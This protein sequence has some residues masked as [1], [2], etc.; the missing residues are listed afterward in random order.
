[1]A[2]VNLD[3][4]DAIVLTESVTTEVFLVLEI[5]TND[6]ITVSES[7]TLFNELLEINI[8]DSII[9]IESISGVASIPGISVNDSTSLTEYINADTVD[10]RIF[11]IT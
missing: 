1:M 6:S 2:D 3:I 5:D 4:L 9:V 7:I 11:L 8:S 10:R